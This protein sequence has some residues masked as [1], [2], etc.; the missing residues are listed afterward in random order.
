MSAAESPRKCNSLLSK[1][2]RFLQKN[3]ESREN[4]L[5]YEP[6]IELRIT[7]YQKKF[8]TQCQ[9]KKEKKRLLPCQMGLI[10]CV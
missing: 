4:G 7:V 2:W 9:L 1:A 6:G 3:E 8:N 10:H 5:A